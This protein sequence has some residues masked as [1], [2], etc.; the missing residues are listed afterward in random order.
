MYCARFRI[1]SGY[2]ESNS[3]GLTITAGG[4]LTF[5]D[6]G[7]VSLT[8]ATAGFTGSTY[9]W[10]TGSS[11]NPLVVTTS[12]NYTVT[13]KSADNCTAPVSASVAVIVN[14]IPP[15]LNDHSRRSAYVL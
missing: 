5:C 6:G 1:G 8:A 10:S 4:P 3:T 9:T 7:S 13:Y 12:G 2:C 14:P 11:D 15:E